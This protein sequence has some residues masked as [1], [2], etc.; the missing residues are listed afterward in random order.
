MMIVSTTGY[1]IAC[2][3]PFFSDYSNNDAAIMKNILHRNTDNIINWFEKVPSI[4]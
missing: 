2:R 4:E 3:D 1:I